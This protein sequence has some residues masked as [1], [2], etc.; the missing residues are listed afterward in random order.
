MKS[1]VVYY[2]CTGNTERIAKLIQEKTN[3]D[4]FKIELKKDY[5]FLD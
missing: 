1:L 3:S 2:S 4:I 5:S